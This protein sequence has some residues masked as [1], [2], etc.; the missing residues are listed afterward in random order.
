MAKKR[1]SIYTPVTPP[2]YPR[3]NCTVADLTTAYTR[4]VSFAV[5]EAARLCAD[6]RRDAPVGFEHADFGWLLN[7]PSANPSDIGGN[8]SL[9]EYLLLRDFLRQF[10]E[11]WDENVRDGEDCWTDATILTVRAMLLREA[12]RFLT[13]T[14]VLFDPLSPSTN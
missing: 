12:V 7:R 6:I 1:P 9:G 3:R 4:F 8:R 5:A 14:M 11:R 10:R 2:P 13:E